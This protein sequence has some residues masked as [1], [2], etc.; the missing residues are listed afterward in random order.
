MKVRGGKR[1]KRKDSE[2]FLKFQTF[3]LVKRIRKA[4]IKKMVLEMDT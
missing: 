2:C 4:Y 3:Y 1:G